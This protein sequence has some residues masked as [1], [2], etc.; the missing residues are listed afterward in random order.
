[1]ILAF[2]LCNDIGDN[3]SSKF[4]AHFKPVFLNTDLNLANVPVPLPSSFEPKITTRAEPLDLTMAIIAKMDEECSQRDCRLI[5]MKFGRFLTTDYPQL[6]NLSD[7]VDTRFAMELHAGYL[8]LD[9][10]FDSR[11]V[12]CH[13]LL[14]GNDDGHWNAF[15]HKLTADIL[16]G[17]L[18]GIG[19]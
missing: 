14:V 13:Q 1:M 10:Q 5:V 16:H 15:G 6:N 2:F 17:F 18:T 7:R 8:D 11:A 19:E 9:A 3:S 4:H 12:T